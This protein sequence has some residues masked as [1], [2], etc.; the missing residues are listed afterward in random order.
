MSSVF[1]GPEALQ[2]QLESYWPYSERW[3]AQ[4]RLYVPENGER[5]VYLVRDEQGRKLCMMASEPRKQP[6]HG[7]T[8]CVVV[9]EPMEQ[10]LALK[11][12]RVTDALDLVGMCELAFLKDKTDQ[13][14]LLEVNPRPWLQIGLARAAGVSLARQASLALAGHPVDTSL[15]AH[16]GIRWVSIERLLISAMSGD[17]G[18]RWSELI[19]AMRT[20]RQADTF[21]IYSA[22]S[23]GV[24]W[25]WF[26]FLLHQA[27]IAEWNCS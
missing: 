25:R 1:A 20:F 26:S 16:S 11:S 5:V 12:A 6:R 27:R 2:Q 17:Y 23:P 7:G 10:E 22:E 18:S 21:A 19:H 15:V 4:P 14:R 13:W 3:V 9:T 24:R 8:S